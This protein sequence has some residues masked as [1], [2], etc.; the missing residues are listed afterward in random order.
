MAV[1][2]IPKIKATVAIDWFEGLISPP[3]AAL[4]SDRP[5]IIAGIPVKNP[6]QVSERIPKIREI[7][8]FVE[9]FGEVI[10]NLFKSFYVASR[11]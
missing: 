7:T 1:P 8:V 9:V 6:Q 5:I 3:L 10:I 2:I 11:Y 4:T